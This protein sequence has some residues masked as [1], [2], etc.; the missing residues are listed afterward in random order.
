VLNGPAFS[1]RG[2]RSLPFSD[3][4]GSIRTLKIWKKVEI[5]K[6]LAFYYLCWYFYLYQ[7]VIKNIHTI[8]KMQ[9]VHNLKYALYVDKQKGIP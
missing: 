8:M 7:D 4:K 1:F 2:R 3:T 5:K 6:Y 9:L